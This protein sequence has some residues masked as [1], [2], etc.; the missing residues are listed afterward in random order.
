MKTLR[1]LGMALMAMMLSVTF[2][3]CGGDDND[4]SGS[5][6]YASAI[7]GRW[8]PQEIQIPFGSAYSTSQ[9]VEFHSDGTGIDCS[10]TNQETTFN[11][12]LDGNK[13][14]LEGYGFSYTI[15]EASASSLT[16]ETNAFGYTLRVIYGKTK[17]VPTKK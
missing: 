11:Y 12:T 13:I 8:Y 16:L 4:G 10:T 5:T 14:V 7:I 17:A 6:D 3:S 1:I 9:W 2:I 15:V